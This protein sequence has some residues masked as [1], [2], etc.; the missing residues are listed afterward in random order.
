MSKIMWH[1][2]LDLWGEL[3]TVEKDHFTAL[4]MKPIHLFKKS[5]KTKFNQAHVKKGNFYVVR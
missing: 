4:C 3:V 5:T 1:T 2:K